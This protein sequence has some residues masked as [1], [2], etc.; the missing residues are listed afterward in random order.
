[1]LKKGY[2]REL[3]G[4]LGDHRSVMGDPYWGIRIF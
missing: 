4:M 1:M 2:S 3:K